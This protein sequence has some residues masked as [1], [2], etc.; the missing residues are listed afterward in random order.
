SAGQRVVTL[1]D[2]PSGVC[3]VAF[4][5]DGRTLATGHATDVRLWEVATGRQ[6][7]VLKGHCASVNCLAF[8]PDGAR[9]A[10]GSVDTTVLLWDW[11]GP[12]ASGSAAGGRVET[13]ELAVLWEALADR[14]AALAF[15]AVCRLRRDPA[16]RVPFPVERL[17]PVR[18]ADPARLDRLIADLQSEQ[19]SVRR[20]AEGELEGLQE[21]A[22]P[23]LRAV[24]DRKPGLELRRRAERLLDRLHAVVPPPDVLRQGAAPLV[25]AGG[26]ADE[27]PRPPGRAARGAQ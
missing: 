12:A 6:R 24:L 9:L 2:C 20:Q 3:S 1:E 17:R 7:G 16:R 5:G 15:R 23:A 14:D 8:S 10:S 13:R 22:E 11:K 25:L 4:S 18:A 21:G 27:G 26:R 19:S